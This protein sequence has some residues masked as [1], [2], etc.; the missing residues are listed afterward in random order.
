MNRIRINKL[1]VPRFLEQARLDWSSNVKVSEH[2]S[3]VCQKP[4]VWKADLIFCK[5][6]TFL[7]HG[8]LQHMSGNRFF[9][10]W[11][12][13]N[14]DMTGS[15]TQ[16]QKRFALANPTRCCRKD[17]L[18]FFFRPV[19]R[20]RVAFIWATVKNAR[21]LRLFI[22]LSVSAADSEQTALWCTRG[23]A[24]WLK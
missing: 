21:P 3:H 9:I 5:E 19:D 4:V 11:H 6:E 20:D 24:D 7:C 18:F 15:F 12:D 8:Q 13:E 16:T 22:S 2:E 10:C 1:I 14:D 23:N 17:L